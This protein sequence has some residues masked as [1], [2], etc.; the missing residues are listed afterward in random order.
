[1]TIS[2]RKPARM[3]LANLKT[4]DTIEAFY[5]PTELTEKIS[6]NYAR[7]QV[8]GLS[9]QPMQ[10][11]NTGNH[12]FD[13]ELAFRVFD[14][15]NKNRIADMDFVRRFLISLCYPIANAVDVVGGAPPHVLFVW[16]QLAALQAKI[17]ELEFKHTMFDLSG[18]PTHS[19]AKLKIEEIRDFRLTSEDAFA[20]GTRRGGTG[21]AGQT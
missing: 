4:G 17:T 20:H 19:A 2:R 14:E 13:F 8:M 11:Q 12:G 5:N 9:H 15:N 7:L 3:S 1:M 18:R 6:V 16:P 10:Y 21:S